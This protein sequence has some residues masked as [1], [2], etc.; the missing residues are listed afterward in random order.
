MALLF[1]ACKTSPG[2]DAGSPDEE[3]AVANLVAHFGSQAQVD[4]VDIALRRVRAA[5][6]S[7]R[8]KLDHEVLAA[9]LERG[10]IAPFEEPLLQFASAECEGLW[11]GLTPP[12]EP[13]DTSLACRDGFCRRSSS[14][15][16]GV[17]VTR[18]A[19][20][21]ACDDSA[22]AF[23][24][25][26]S[27]ARCR[28]SRCEV[29]PPPGQVGEGCPCA[30]GLRCTAAGRCVAPKTTGAA[31]TN[32]SECPL[33]DRCLDSGVCGLLP[34]GAAC[35]T[36]ALCGRGLVCRF[37]T[38]GSTCTPLVE[39]SFCT[40]PDRCPDG[41]VC[42]LQR[43]FS[44]CRPRRAANEACV[45]S[46]Q[47]PRGFACADGS[48]RRVL[49][50]GQDC[51][52]PSTTCMQGSFCVNGRC[53]RRPREGEAC[54]G[55]CAFS[56]CRGGQCVSRGVGAAC[57]PHEDGVASCGAGLRCGVDGTCQAAPVAG[58][59]CPP[60]CDEGSECIDGRC[61]EAC[62]LGDG[63][64]RGDFRGPAAPLVVDAGCEASGPAE[65]VIPLTDAQA[66]CAFANQPSCTGCHRAGGCWELRPRSPPVPPPP[67]G[68]GL[69]NPACG[70]DAGR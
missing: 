47:C 27:G 40:T 32:D 39:G 13:C 50:P 25:C 33:D 61:V 56:D 19:I 9:C 16:C 20:G 2:A 65:L 29:I 3:D 66:A 35:T 64:A 10:S 58:A 6:R 34:S 51:T 30:D 67:A 36:D 28:S 63:T 22:G 1:I 12:G 11:V 59:S 69:L 24:Q 68:I 8:L 53:S 60:A 37:V 14:S 42:T 21:A 15:V 54:L 23:T 49:A 45:G 17:C 48:C 44:R 70:I 5:L 52:S 62:V 26:V 4:D 38:P 57:T 55:S 41:L 31:C 43:A 46:A 18:I 7:G